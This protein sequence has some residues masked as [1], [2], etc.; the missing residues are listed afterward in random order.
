[1]IEIK[2][3]GNKHSFNHHILTWNNQNKEDNHP[4]INKYGLSVWGNL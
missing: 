2:Y 3:I 1:M 4:T